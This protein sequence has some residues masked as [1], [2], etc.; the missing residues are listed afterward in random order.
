MPGPRMDA[1]LQDKI[2]DLLD[3][4]LRITD[5]SDET[6]RSMTTIQAFLERHNYKRPAPPAVWSDRFLCLAEREEISRGLSSGDSFRKIAIGLGRAPSTVSR[7]VNV[8]GGREKY[9]AVVGEGSIRER[10][11]RPK[12]TK[13]GEVFSLR[14]IVES[15]L[16]KK[17]SP[18]QIS[19][20]LKLIYPDQPEMWVSYE[21]IYKSLY[22]D[23]YGVL[24]Y[25]LYR[26]LRSKRRSRKPRKHR[27]RR[28]IGVLKGYTSVHVRPA[29]IES[30]LTLGHW[31]GDLV[32]GGK[33]TVVATL[34]ER[35]TKYLKIIKMPGRSADNLADAMAYAFKHMPKALRGSLTWDQGKE[36]AGH[37][38]TE[39]RTKMDVYVCDPRSPCLMRTLTASSESTCREELTSKKSARKN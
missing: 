29:E 5:I 21:T 22:K 32:V 28:G 23:Y 37:K 36:I 26:N 13:L 38:N 6:G 8:N 15:L 19:G 12:R 10:A 7:E 20:R 35:K 1:V 24:D 27:P 33:S 14:R 30:K 4:G 2:W 39:K 11:R 9:R 18:Q 31:E 16:V 3:S 25:D 34:V 17:W